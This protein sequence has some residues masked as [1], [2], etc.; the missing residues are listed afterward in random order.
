MGLALPDWAQ[1]FR[2]TPARLKAAYGGRA[3]GKSRSVAIAL[4]LIAMERRVRIACVR[5]FMSSIEESAKQELEDAIRE[6]DL[7]DQFSVLRNKIYC[8]ATGSEFFFL[9]FDR[10]KQSMKSWSN[11]DICWVEEA[12]TLDPESHGLLHPSVR[13]DNS[14]IWF[15]FNPYQRSDPVWQDFC[16]AHPRP[17]AMIVKVNWMDNPFLPKVMFNEQAM[18]KER[19]PETYNHHWLGETL[20]DGEIRKVLPYALVEMCVDAHNKFGWKW[21]SRHTHGGLDIADTGGDKNAFVVR[22]GPLIR[23]VDAWSAE[24]VKITAIRADRWAVDTSVTRLWYDGTGV[25]AGIR[26]YMTEIAEQRTYSTLPIDFGSKVAGK[27]RHFSYA[28]TNEQMFTRRKDQL[29]WALRMRAE[30]TK[31]LYNGENVPLQ[32]C[33]FIDRDIPNLEDYLLQ[34]SQPEWKENN[35]SKIVIE[36]QPDDAPS[37]D[38]YD[39]TVLAFARDSQYGLTLHHWNS[40]GNDKATGKAFNPRVAA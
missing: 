34:L 12:H 11:V 38:K 19:W 15:T 4:L 39:A 35:S 28:T 1:E 13:K 32:Y 18:W 26:P 30:N 21:N 27:E 5:Q 14:E 33:L 24:H 40:D 25:G 20:D 16:S 10:S 37:P 29:G 8:K 3:S 17:D 23:A 31:R 2:S 7:E 6:G 9:G 22:T 36:K